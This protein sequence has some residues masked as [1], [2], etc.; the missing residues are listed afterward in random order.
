MQN[1]TSPPKKR[2]I[3]TIVVV[4]PLVIVALAIFLLI[5]SWLI[6]K[7]GYKSIESRED[8]SEKPLPKVKSYYINLYIQSNVGGADVYVNGEKQASGTRT[9]DL[10]ASVFGLRPG[11]YEIQLK[12]EGYKDATQTVKL[13]GDKAV[14]TI[15]MELESNP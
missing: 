11:T 13:T 2:G 12:K 1:R 9:S 10:K 8:I 3:P 7:M 14:E 4:I 5:L 6:P 15:I